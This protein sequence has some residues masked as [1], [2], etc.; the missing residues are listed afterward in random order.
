MTAQVPDEFRY[1]GGEEFSL[2]GMVGEGLFEPETDFNLK[3]F[4][5]CTA[6]WRGY[7]MTYDC[8]DGKLVLQRM[9]INIDDPQEINGIKP[10]K[11]EDDDE[12]YY[13][14]KLVYENLNLKTRFTGKLLLAKDFINSMYVHMGYQRPM[15][16]KTVL[17]IHV[18]DGEI[19]EERNLSK[20][21]AE[22][23]KK[24]RKKDARPDSDSETDIKGWIEKSFSLDYDLD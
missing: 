13:G 17:E 9:Y 3:P 4:S 19:T 5:T 22:L 16:Y 14:F 15:A 12:N 24:D 18:K 1:G 21:M 6:C 2:V 10:R 7:Q 20:K 8:V 11:I 23:R